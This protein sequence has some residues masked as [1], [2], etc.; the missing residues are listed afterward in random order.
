M[1]LLVY[2]KNKYINNEERGY[3]GISDLMYPV[4]HG[5]L[6]WNKQTNKKEWTFEN[7]PSIIPVKYARFVYIPV[8][9]TFD[10]SLSVLQ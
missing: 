7:K 6:I 8:R 3:F 10:S 2:N 9:Q 5:C 4:T 1:E